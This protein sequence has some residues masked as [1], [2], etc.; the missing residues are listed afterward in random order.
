MT[1]KT[2]NEEE[3]INYTLMTFNYEGFD[4]FET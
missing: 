2:H 1:Y 3:I 4:S